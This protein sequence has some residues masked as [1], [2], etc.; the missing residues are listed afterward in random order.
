MIMIRTK[1]AVIALLIFLLAFPISSAGCTAISD[2]VEKYTPEK[3]TTSDWS[4]ELPP[5]FNLLVDAWKMVNKNYV[6]KDKIDPKKL[7]QGAIRGMVDALGDPH[8][9][10]VDPDLYKLETSSL[11]GKY[12]GIGAYV[13]VRDKQ[14]TIISPMVGSPA[15]QAGVKPGDIVLE[16]DGK[17]TEGMSSTEAALTIQGPAGSSVK[18]LLLR[19]GETKPFEVSIIRREITVKSVNWERRDRIGYIQLT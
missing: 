16:I 12:T 19:Q 14:L 11:R 18:L 4:S 13:G 5:D 9:V 10:Y 1:I 8:S 15:E 2:I 6:D 3:K 7:S 17:S